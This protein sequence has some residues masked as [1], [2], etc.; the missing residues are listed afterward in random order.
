MMLL[1]HNDEVMTNFLTSLHFF[2]PAFVVSV[3]ILSMLYIEIDTIEIALF[4]VVTNFLT[5]WRTFWCHDVFLTPWWTIWR[6]FDV[7]TYWRYDVV[8]THTVLRWDELFDVMTYFCLLLPHPK[9]LL[10]IQI[11][12]D[13][14]K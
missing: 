13:A 4:G 7:M 1:W 14:V 3:F 6:I 10:D 5:S 2:V 9:M 12:R 11:T 8:L